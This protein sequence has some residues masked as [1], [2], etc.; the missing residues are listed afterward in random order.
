MILCIWSFNIHSTL[1]DSQRVNKLIRQTARWATA[2]DQDTNAYIA[3]L[4]STYALGY[5]MALREIYSDDE[6]SRL[7]RVD[8]RKLETQVTQIMDNSLKKL[9]DIC[10]E[11]QPKNKFLAFL[12][13][14]GGY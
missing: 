1:T 11:G 6:I 7:S 13:K 10:P 8:I 2:A 14:E 4:H 9:I 3:N 12:S 5:L